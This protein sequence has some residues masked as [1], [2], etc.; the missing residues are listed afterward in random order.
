MGTT[1][2]A[3]KL[4]PEYKER[5]LKALRSGDYSQGKGYLKTI[6]NRYCC[7]GVLCDIFSEKVNGTWKLAESGTAFGFSLGNEFNIGQKCFPPTE[8]NT[9]VH[10][11][12]HREV[13]FLTYCIPLSS[14]DYNRLSALYILKG[15]TV[16]L[17]DLN[18]KGVPFSEIA[19]L[20]EKYL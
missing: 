5:W 11:L 17:S 10:E 4:K 9:L 13:Q 12:Y 1:R 3:R 2:V 16:Y 18:D 7:L 19:D 6:D 15:D 14:E 20:I 8:L